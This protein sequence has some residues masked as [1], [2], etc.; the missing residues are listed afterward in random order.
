MARFETADAEMFFG[1]DRLDAELLATATGRPFIAVVGP[2]GSG[3]LLALRPGLLPGYKP[4]SYRAGRR[5]PRSPSSR[6]VIPPRHSPPPGR[7][8][9][10]A[11]PACL[12]ARASESMMV[13]NGLAAGHVARKRRTHSAR[14]P[15]R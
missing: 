9:P 6:D 11:R 8:R 3:K 14:C 1:R 4:V 10:V 15:Q 5:R 13:V 2:S 7:T 12:Q